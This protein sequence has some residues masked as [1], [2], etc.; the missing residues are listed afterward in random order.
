MHIVVLCFVLLWLSYLLLE[1]H[2]IDLPISSWVASLALG[3]SHDCP[4]A[5]EVTLKDM[6]YIN[7]CLPTP[8]T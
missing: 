3:Q 5:S 7:Q 6:G 2:V 8:K 4:S 1:I